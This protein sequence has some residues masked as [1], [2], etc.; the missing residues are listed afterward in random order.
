MCGI[1][2]VP[3]NKVRTAYNRG[4]YLAQRRDLMQTWRDY[5][6]ERD[7]ALTLSR[8]INATGGGRGASISPR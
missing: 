2:H 5:L 1:I 6:D 4:L 3:S 7:R 8:W